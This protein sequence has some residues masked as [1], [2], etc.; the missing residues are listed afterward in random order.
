MGKNY[1]ITFNKQIAKELRIK[2]NS[3]EY[4]SRA[5]DKIASQLTHLLFKKNGF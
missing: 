3:P 4:I 1:L 2:L 5:I